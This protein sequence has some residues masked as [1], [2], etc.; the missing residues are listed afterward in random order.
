MVEDSGTT[1]FMFYGMLNLNKLAKLLP[2]P[3]E[4]SSKEAR[5]ADLKS[6]AVAL[7]CPGFTRV[8]ASRHASIQANPLGQIKTFGVLLT[9]EQGRFTDEFEEVDD[10][11]YANVEVDVVLHRPGQPDQLARARVYQMTE[12]TVEREIQENLENSN[13]NYVME[14]ANS[15]LLHYELQGHDLPATIEVPVTKIGDMRVLRTVIARPSQLKEAW[16]DTDS[17]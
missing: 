8:F 6:K 15:D 10:L 17:D 5:L 13:D 4:L 2:F 7:T 11:Y 16:Y 1:L 9:Q 3:S 14:C 12:R